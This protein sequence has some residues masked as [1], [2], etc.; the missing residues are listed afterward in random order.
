MA[1]ENFKNFEKVE[2]DLEIIRRRKKLL[3]KNKKKEL[4]WHKKRLSRHEDIIVGL[5]K[6]EEDVIDVVV[7]EGTSKCDSVGLKEKIQ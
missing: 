2:D 1:K 7:K 5:S 6:K 3:N 4:I